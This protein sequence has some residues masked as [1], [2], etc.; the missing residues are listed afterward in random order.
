MQNEMPFFEDELDALKA[1]VQA[2]GG[3]KKVGQM[4]WQDKGVDAASRL[5]LDSLN[6]GRNE[7][8]SLSQVIFILRAAKDAGH[9]GP[10]Q[11]IA[12]EIGYDAHPVSRAEEADR[13]LTVIEQSTKQLAAALRAMENLKNNPP[14]GDRPV[15]RVAPVN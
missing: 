11:W 8:L 13:M 3:S 2:L 6:P 10:F 7:K 5:L 12:G 4:L 15:V 9:H 14:A 1:A